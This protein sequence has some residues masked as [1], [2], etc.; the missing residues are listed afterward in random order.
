MLKGNQMPIVCL[1]SP[2]YYRKT[3]ITSWKCDAKPVDGLP[4]HFEN[5]NN[6]I[7]IRHN[8]GKGRPKLRFP[9][10][11]FSLRLGASRL[12]LCTLICPLIKCGHWISGPKGPTEFEILW[13]LYSI[14]AYQQFLMVCSVLGLNFQPIFLSPIKK[15]LF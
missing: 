5:H 13:V 8:T 15:N 10:I 12:C 9:S 4:G 3:F 11:H 1:Y 14:K 6:D 2:I 7:N